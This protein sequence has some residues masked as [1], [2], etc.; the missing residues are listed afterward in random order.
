MVYILFQ[1]W[2]RRVPRSL[3]SDD[4]G[5]KRAAPS[6][7]PTSCLKAFS[8]ANQTLTW[9]LNNSP[10]LPS[11]GQTG[12][13]TACAAC[14]VLASLAS[15]PIRVRVLLQRRRPMLKENIVIGFCW[16][17]AMLKRIR[18]DESR[19]VTPGVRQYSFY[20]LCF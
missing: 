19:L 14:L 11:S 9:S 6:A 15:L 1:V 16:K 8:N 18:F 5:P 7:S 12:P 2:S 4:T 3:H 10:Q 20:G 17:L 13:D